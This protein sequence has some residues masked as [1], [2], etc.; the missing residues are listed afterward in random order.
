MHPEVAPLKRLISG[1]AA[2]AAG[3]LWNNDVNKLIKTI[4]MILFIFIMVLLNSELPNQRSRLPRFCFLNRRGHKGK[5][6]VIK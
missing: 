4:K 1:R 3:K 2:F 5:S 6:G